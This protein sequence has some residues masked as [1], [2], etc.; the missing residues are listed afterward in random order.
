MPEIQRINITLPRK[1]VERSRILI[2]E[3]LYG[4]FSELVRE[5]IRNEILLDAP[6]IEKKSLLDKWFKEEQGRG[7]D[8][9]A[10]SQEEIIANIRRS[11]DALWDKRH[12]RWF[13]R[14]AK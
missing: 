7:V 8:T 11:R 2:D 14:I 12:Q 13:G 1:L 4:N 6:L 3:G 10:F 5:S 9:S